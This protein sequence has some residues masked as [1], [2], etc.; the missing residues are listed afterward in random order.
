MALKF[1][2]SIN[3]N[4]NE[5]QNAV[6]QNLATSPS[7]PSAGLIYYDTALNKLGYYNG[8]TWIYGSTTVVQGTA[9]ITVSVSGD[10]YTVAISG[11][12]TSTPGSM[13]AADKTKLDNATSNGTP[14][15]LVLRDGSGNATFNMLTLTGNPTNPTDVVNLQY[16][17]GLING[18]DWKNSVRAATTANITLSGTQTIDGVSLVVGNRVLVKNQTTGSQNGYYLVASGA[19]TRT[20]DLA[21]GF[22]AA[23]VTTWVEE[24]TIN[25]DSTWTCTSDVGSDIVG[26]SS[27]IFTQTSGTGQITA[28]AGLTK[29]GNVIDVVAGDQSINVQPDSIAVRVD[30]STIETNVSNGIQVKAGGITATQ[31][32][33]SALGTTLTGGSGTV[34]NVNGYTFVSGATVTR[35][36]TLTGNIGGGTATTFTHN[37]NTR[38]VQIQILDASTFEPYFADWSPA[39]VNTVTVTAVGT[40]TSVRV[41]IVG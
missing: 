27:L 7:S 30:N 23:N 6:V 29:T 40:S 9:P 10:T 26:T 41:V 15:T 8:T 35:K 21:A 3:L 17:N 13:S 37:L 14:N 24:G 31:I 11:A 18:L 38:D 16:V 39:T 20:A 4:R 19:W 25:G 1:L 22:S 32:N 5:L 33:S 12:T 36:I 2:S 34:I 28:G